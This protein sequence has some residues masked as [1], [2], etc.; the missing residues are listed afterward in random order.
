MPPKKDASEAGA[1]GPAEVIAGF[2]GKETK[3]LAAAFV[4]ATATGKV[5]Q[6]PMFFQRTILPSYR[7]VA[8]DR[9][10]VE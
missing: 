4:A 5:S 6:A 8:L 3:Y 10:P 9:N 2:S 7:V 1:A